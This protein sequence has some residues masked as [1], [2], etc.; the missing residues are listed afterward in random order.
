MNVNIS[1]IKTLYT[2]EVLQKRISELAE[3]LDKEYNGEEIVAIAVLN[4]A[5]YF[6]TDLTKKMKTVIELDTVHVTS[7]KGTESTGSIIVRKDIGC[8]ITDKHVLIVE[9]IIDSGRTLKYLK[10]YLMKKNPKSLKI[11]VLLDKKER[12]VEEVDIDYV[13]FEI[14]NKF[15]VGY[16][17]D[18][19]GKYRSLP[20]I[21]YIETE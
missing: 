3:E 13:G 17:F 1:D 7:Y 8:D 18:I 16:G 5:I 10:E 2:E 21:G 19:D 6:Y 9:D 4:G 12:R 11:A 14:P 20:Y 15:V